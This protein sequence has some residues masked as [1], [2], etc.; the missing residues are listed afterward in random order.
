MWRDALGGQAIR[1]NNGVNGGVNGDSVDS[2]DIVVVS[3][4]AGSGGVAGATGDA[5]EADHQCSNA[6]D[7]WDPTVSSEGRETVNSEGS[8]PSRPRW[9]AL[10][11]IDAK[12]ALLVRPDG[13][14]AWRAETH[15]G[16]DIVPELRRVMG[17]MLCREWP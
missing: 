11:G 8:P 10:R 2:I 13:H 12:G 15:V 9:G 14:V 17:G 7:F 3:M 16:L 6:D 1:G 5:G 4:A